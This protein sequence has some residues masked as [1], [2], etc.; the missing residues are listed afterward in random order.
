[1][2]DGFSASPIFDTFEMLE[3]ICKKCGGEC[4]PGKALKQIL[5][6]SGVPDFE[7]DP[8]AARGSTMRLLATGDLDDCLKCVDCGWSFKQDS[9][10]Q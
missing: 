6:P 1:M 5:V 10:D 4:K 3:Y 2:V 7:C 8:V 9:I